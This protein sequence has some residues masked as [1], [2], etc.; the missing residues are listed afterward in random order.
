MVVHTLKTGSSLF[1]VQTGIAHAQKKMYYHMARNFR[2]PIFS[3]FISNP[4]FH[5][6]NIHEYT[7]TKDHACVCVVQLQW[8][9]EV[10]V[11]NLSTCS[12]SRFMYTLDCSFRWNSLAGMNLEMFVDHASLINYYLHEINPLP[13]IFVDSIFHELLFSGEFCENIGPQK[14]LVIRYN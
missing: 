11:M 12:S 1:K 14:F 6:K 10:L 7:I 2:G 8:Q 4:A 9:W 3:R 5:W 13:N